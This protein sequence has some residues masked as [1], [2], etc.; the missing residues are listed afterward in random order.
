MCVSAG[1]TSTGLI[2]IIILTSMLQ[3]NLQRPTAAAVSTTTALTSSTPSPQIMA[4]PISSGTRSATV[5]V[6]IRE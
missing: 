3:E 4:T 6:I 2:I 5:T 1:Q